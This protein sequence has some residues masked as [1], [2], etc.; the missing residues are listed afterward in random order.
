LLYSTLLYADQDVIS[1][2]PLANYNQS[3]TA[4]IK[5]NDTD[6]DT[7]LLNFQVQNSHVKIFYQHYFDSSSPW[8][9]QY[10]TNILSQLNELK[11]LE[12]NIINDFSKPG[13][14]ENFHP[15]SPEWI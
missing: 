10:V 7:L 11:S 5:P 8:D 12:Q 2:F 1:V 3:V 14:G 9:M 4:W 15:Y 6:Y 13:Y